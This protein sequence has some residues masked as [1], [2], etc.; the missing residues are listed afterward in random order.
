MYDLD[1]SRTR[2]RGLCLRARHEGG[3]SDQHGRRLCPGPH[4]AAATSR[5]HLTQGAFIIDFVTTLV[6]CK[7]SPLAQIC[8]C[9]LLVQGAQLSTRLP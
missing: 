2:L 5:L 8:L 7:I 3:A 4:A 6:I 1:R 9:L